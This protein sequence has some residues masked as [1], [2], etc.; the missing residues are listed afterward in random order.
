MEIQAF[1][2]SSEITVR[3][4]VYG[5]LAPQHPP[6][7]CLA[8]YS[9]NGSD[10]TTVAEALSANRIVVVVD[11]RGRGMSDWAPDE[12]YSAEHESKD[13]LE[14]LATLAWPEF[15]VIGTSRG[16]V[17]AQIIAA[18]LPEQ[19][20]RIVLNDVGPEFDMA[21]L[22]A[23]DASLK[24]RANTPPTNWLQARAM[25]QPLRESFFPA[26]TDADF[27]A[28]VRGS[29][30]EKNGVLVSAFDPALAQVFTRNFDPE[31]PP[32]LWPL[33]ETVK[34]KPILLVWGD[35]STLLRRHMVDA[36]KTAKPDMELLVA[37]GQAHPPALRSKEEISMIVNFLG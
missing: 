27:D 14:V 15:D 35:R 4:R 26:W 19:V 25:L 31:N 22:L 9:R 29:F 33:F 8:G 6:V 18:C 10:F 37:K 2:M 3:A 23:I 24:A 12:T 34:H 7:L 13:V 20:R 11:T 30:T 21:G 1:K 17:L 28:F 16:G 5:C 32:N 36:M